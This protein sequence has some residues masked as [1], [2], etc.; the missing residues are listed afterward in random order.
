MRA[1]IW[2]KPLGGIRTQITWTWQGLFCKLLHGGLTSTLVRAWLPHSC[3][4]F[5]LLLVITQ[6]P[7]SKNLARPVSGPAPPSDAPCGVPSPSQFPGLSPASNPSFTQHQQPWSTTCYDQKVQEYRNRQLWHAG[8]ECKFGIP[9]TGEELLCAG[10]QQNLQQSSA[11]NY[12]LHTRGQKH[13]AS[14]RCCELSCCIPS[15]NEIKEWI[16]RFHL[17]WPPA[18]AWNTWARSA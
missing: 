9:I 8:W 17:C 6:F 7:Q 16:L 12:N 14:R 5:A 1:L 15:S 2:N 3:L 13:M 18:S 10:T 11:G 4:C